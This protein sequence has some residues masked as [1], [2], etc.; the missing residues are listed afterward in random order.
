MCIFFPFAVGFFLASLARPTLG[1]SAGEALGG[2]PAQ[3][4]RRSCTECVEKHLGSAA[5]LIGEVHD[6]YTEHKLLAIGHLAEAAEESRRWP[7][8]HDAIR[9]ARRAYQNDGVAPD[10]GYLAALLVQAKDQG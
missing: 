2:A 1:A 9:E 6:G 3:E 5:V 7:A 10:F 8:L 4:P